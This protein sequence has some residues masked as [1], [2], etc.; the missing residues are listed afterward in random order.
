MDFKHSL[1]IQEIWYVNIQSCKNFLYEFLIN[2][3][4]YFLRI[5]MLGLPNLY[6]FLY[7]GIPIL[8]LFN[9]KK[10]IN[11]FIVLFNKLIKF[12]ST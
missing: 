6:I 3:L 7:Y 4:R 10:I 9:I 11:Y 2:F 1:T 8:F 5:F 12:L